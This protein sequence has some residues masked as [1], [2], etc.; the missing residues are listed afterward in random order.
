[1]SGAVSAATL[2]ETQ[3]EESYMEAVEALRRLALHLEPDDPRAAA[4]VTRA[5]DW[6]RA[7]GP[8]HSR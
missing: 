5:R 6:L 3:E 4:Y 1:V 7:T 8:R 2:A